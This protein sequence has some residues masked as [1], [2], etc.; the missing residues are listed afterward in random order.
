MS[1]WVKVEFLG[2][3]DREPG[4][5]PTAVSWSAGLDLRLVQAILLAAVESLDD[6]FDQERYDLEGPQ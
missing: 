2:A 3:D 5:F 4:V 1:V 6:S